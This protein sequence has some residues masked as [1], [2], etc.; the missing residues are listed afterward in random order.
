MYRA[1][2]DFLNQKTYLENNRRNVP[3]SQ[4]LRLAVATLVWETMTVDHEG[5]ADEYAA[6]VRSINH[7]F[8]ILDAESG[9]LL[10]S[11]ALLHHHSHQLDKALSAINQEYDSEQRKQLAEILLRVAKADGHINQDEGEFL[12]IINQKLNLKI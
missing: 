12:E 1:F 5:S 10:H 8:H 4:A 6:A 3:A 11:A 2:K 7:E 9:D